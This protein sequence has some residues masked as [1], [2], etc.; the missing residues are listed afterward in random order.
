MG[1][2]GGG[3]GRY[4]LCTCSRACMCRGEGINRG[5]ITVKVSLASSRPDQLAMNQLQADQTAELT[6]QTSP[7]KLSLRSGC[8]AALL[9]Q[10]AVTLARMKP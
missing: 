8:S 1:F 2:A 5:A 10:L 7:L 3:G 6:N 4:A 9:S